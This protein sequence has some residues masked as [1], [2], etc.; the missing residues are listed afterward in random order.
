MLYFGHYVHSILAGQS[1]QSCKHELVPLLQLL[2]CETS[3]HAAK[4]CSYCQVGTHISAAPEV[5]CGVSS[6]QAYSE[7][8]LHV[9]LHK[10]VCNTLSM[11]LQCKTS[12]MQTFQT[13]TADLSKLVITDGQNQVIHSN[14]FNRSNHCK[15]HLE[16]SCSC[17]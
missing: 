14:T 2:C 4:C 6:S 5:V 11:L 15:L 16:G 17:T 13:L 3:Y 8:Y 1:L 7:V 9:G 12:Q 10:C